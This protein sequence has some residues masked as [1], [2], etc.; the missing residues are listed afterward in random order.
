L[1]EKPR[2]SGRRAGLSYTSYFGLL[3]EGSP[4][5][6]APKTTRGAGIGFQKERPRRSG[7]K[8]T[9][10]QLAE[11]GVFWPSA[12]EQFG[13]S[14][15]GDSVPPAASSCCQS[16]AVEQQVSFPNGEPGPRVFTLGSTEVGARVL[17]ADRRFPLPPRAAP[18]HSTTFGNAPR[19]H[20]CGCAGRTLRAMFPRPMT[21]RPTRV[22]GGTW[23]LR[24]AAIP[25]CCWG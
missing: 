16:V 7:A 15:R 10:H 6:S 14:E 11:G 20:N 5:P 17:R 19:P 22:V 24:A 18:E 23:S 25:I 9:G 21:R 12:A 3:A 8:C 1:Q 13:N 2:P 4:V